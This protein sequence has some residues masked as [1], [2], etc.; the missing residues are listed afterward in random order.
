MK[1]LRFLI[2]LVACLA[3]VTASAQWQWV[4]RNGK[5]VFSDLPPPADVPEQ[6]ILKR[7]GGRAAAAAAANGASANPASAAL[8][9]A[10]TDKTLEE[11]RKQLEGVEA[12]RRKAEEERIA[13]QKAE[14]CAKAQQAKAALDA[15]GR[16][17][18]MNERGERE[19]LDE[20]ALAAEQQ[21]LQAM[22]NENCL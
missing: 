17:A 5:R 3:V 21:R 20:S 7:P 15:G 12:A 13:R 2:S 22:I 4:D 8:P 19:F 11:R 6:N 16:V 14:N 1:T 18:R 9:T 10:G